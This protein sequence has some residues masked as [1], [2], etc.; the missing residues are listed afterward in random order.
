MN[1]SQRTFLSFIILLT[2]TLT[3]CQ[4]PETISEKKDEFILNF[5]LEKIKQRGYLVV[6]MDNNTTGYFIYRGR[7]MGYEYELLKRFADEQDLELR[8]DVT[9]SLEEAFDKLNRGETDILAYNLTVTKERKLRTDFTKYHNLVRQVLIQRKPDGWQKMH[10]KKIDRLSLRNPVDL[11]GKTVIVRHHSAH[12]TRLENLSEEIGG[13]I[14]IRED[15]SNV[16]TEELIRKVANGTIDYTIAEEDVALVNATFYP[17]IDVKTAVSFPQQIA[18]G[19]RKNAD[20]LKN[21]LNT[22]IVKMKKKP[23]YHVIYNRYFKNRHSLLNPENEYFTFEGGKISPYDDLIKENAKDLGWDWRL[24]AAQIYK[25]SKFNPTAV[26][27]AGA[28]GLMQLMPNTSQ[29]HGV[30]NPDDPVQ[31]IGAGKKHLKWLQ[32]IWKDEIPD[33]EERTK[34]V[35][36]SFNVG[37]GHVQDAVALA[38]KDGRS[39]E[40]W[41]N[42]VEV[43]LLRKS[44]RQFYNDPVVKYGYCRGTETV[45][46]VNSVQSIYQTY[47]E[48]VEDEQ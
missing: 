37:Q 3:G 19:V 38:K 10:P 18:W 23:A 42:E 15:S 45:D 1:P 29:A 13:E 25:E 27:W 9:K 20:S 16:E 48:L 4:S 43:Y 22:W 47:L 39:G 7:T 40:V 6:S 28:K 36:A 35:L 11:I 8:I 17:N 21:T 46:Y 44:K 31:N 41:H 33:P 12:K 34:F 2:L 14:D 5:D 24:L 32:N 30:T 26:S